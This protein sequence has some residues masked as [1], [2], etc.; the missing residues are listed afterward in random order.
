MINQI[1]EFLNYLKVEKD[2]SSHTIKNYRSDLLQFVEFLTEKDSSI[3]DRINDIDH[4]TIRNFLAGIKGKNYSRSTLIRKIAS[5]R[6]FF[7]YLL[8]ETHVKANPAAGMILPKKGRHLPEFLDLSEMNKLLESP[9]VSK[10]TGLRDR[11]LMEVLYSS[12]IRVSELVNL[13]ESSVDL[14][15]EVVKVRGK[16]KK[17]RM[18]PLGSTAVKYLTEYLEQR[19]SGDY[20]G[21]KPNFLAV[22][23]NKYGQRITDRSVR[24]IINKYIEEAAIGHKISPHVLRHTFATHM[25]DAGA[26][27]R[28]V[29]ELL[30]HASLSTTQIYTH[31]T[32]DK[33]KKVYNKAHPRA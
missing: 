7:R 10:L 17:E 6:S 19:K 16:G 28:S 31:I 25:L 15:G 33:M 18:V 27:L 2:A 13:N 1:A 29:Q 8:R 11:V 5:I 23:L 9:D 4:I 32:A 20:K 21:R 24:R 22:F 30:G 12:G 26:D 14:I 3:L